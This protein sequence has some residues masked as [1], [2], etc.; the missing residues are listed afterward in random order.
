MY[1]GDL[2][3]PENL[4]NFGVMKCFSSDGEFEEHDGQEINTEYLK[5]FTKMVQNASI[6]ANRLSSK[7][8]LSAFQISFHLMEKISYVILSMCK[9]SKEEIDEL[10]SFR[11]AWK[12]PSYP[13]CMIKNDSPM[14]VCS[15]KTQ[16]LNENGDCEVIDQQESQL[17]VLIEEEEEEESDENLCDSGIASNRDVNFI[18]ESTISN[19]SCQKLSPVNEN[20]SPNNYSSKCLSSPF[21]NE[22]SVID[23]DENCSM[24]ADKCANVEVL[25]V[26]PGTTTS[27]MFDN[28]SKQIN[29]TENI[30]KIQLK[31]RISTIRKTNSTNNDKKFENGS[32]SSDILDQPN[33]NSTELYESQTTILTNKFQVDAKRW[34]LTSADKLNTLIDECERQINGRKLYVCKFCGKIYEIKSSMRYHMKIIHLQMHLRTTEMQ[35]R[36][37]GK[38]F[39]CVSAVNRHQSKCILSTISDSR[40]KNNTISS[41]QSLF[42]SPIMTTITTTSS[43]TDSDMHPRL[44]VNSFTSQTSDSYNNSLNHNTSLTDSDLMMESLSSASKNFTN[45][46]HFPSAFRIPDICCT[47]TQFMNQSIPKIYQNSQIRSLNSRNF[48]PSSDLVNLP[49]I[50]NSNSLPFQPFNSSNDTRSLLNSVNNHSMNCSYSSSQWNSSTWSTMSNLGCNFTALTPAQIDICMKAV[51]QGICSTVG[52]CTTTTNNNDNDTNRSSNN[53]NVSS[54]RTN[55]ESNESDHVPTDSYQIT[56]ETQWNL[57][58]K[59]L[60]DFSETAERT[61]TSSQANDTVAIDLSSRPQSASLIIE[62]F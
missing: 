23:I 45:L 10:K 62:S 48:I 28:D 12:Y 25:V 54:Y 55:Q 49:N 34:R 22:S 32:I 38:Q 15:M 31:N 56:D 24:I 44:S 16:S 51:V 14:G 17:K 5:K 7:E 19:S 36:I 30:S 21:T 3:W 37:C 27:E 33:N 41:N 61:L 6:L 53:N 2:G 60:L 50:S 42:T 46:V 8:L 11:T 26:V 40:F 9:S 1:T 47:T 59:N 4:C 20:H 58:N 39:T 43:S 35:C 13:R 57:P 52:Q 18:T 29:M